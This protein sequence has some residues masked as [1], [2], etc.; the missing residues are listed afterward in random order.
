MGF[1]VKQPGMLALLQDAGRF[2]QHRIGL[3]TGGPL[4][5]RAFD[6]CNALL[7]NP[8]G[9]TAV[10]LSFGGLE[11]VA[12]EDTFICVTGADAPLTIAGEEQPLY[13]V[14]PVRAGDTVHL[15][16]SEN[17]C[18]SYLGVADGFKV[19]ESFGS[20]STVVREGIGG[21]QGGKLEAGDTLHCS[22]ISTRKQL[23]LPA[24]HRPVYSDELTVRVI[25]GYQLSHFPRYQQRRFFSLPY[26][27]STRSDRMGYRMEGPEISC[28]IQGIL[29]EGICLGAIQVPADGQPIV[30]LN[31]RQTIGGYPKI[32]AALSL[33]LALLAQLRPGQQVHFTPISQHEAHNALHLAAN[34]NVTALFEDLG[35]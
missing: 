8:V 12:T 14:L 24:Q 22:A 1:T 20:T 18:R 31:D 33:D 26:T 15:G 30:L 2:G 27:V 9:T 3:T 32:G 11:L 28:D 16:F 35:T 13:T 6:L 23:Q 4:D 25:P 17:G 10:E 29:S 7:E 19:T 5:K 34:N 21:L